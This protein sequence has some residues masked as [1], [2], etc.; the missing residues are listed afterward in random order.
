ML[1]YVFWNLRNRNFRQKKQDEKKCL[2]RRPRAI[3]WPGASCTISRHLRANHI[4]YEQGIQVVHLQGVS[5]LQQNV[6]G[7]VPDHLEANV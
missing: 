3:V 5:P 1:A 2:P 6:E 4:G 7:L